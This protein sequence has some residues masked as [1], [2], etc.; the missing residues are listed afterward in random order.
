[1]P[2]KRSAR[3]EESAQSASRRGAGRNTRDN[4]LDLIEWSSPAGHAGM[5]PIAGTPALAVSKLPQIV[6]QEHGGS[7][8][9]QALARRG[10]RFIQD[11][12][13]THGRQSQLLFDD[14]SSKVLVILPDEEVHRE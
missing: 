2:W 8:I 1:M 7:I 14:R 6:G 5:V 3:G 12:G 10:R 13:E 9:E 11:H 4:F